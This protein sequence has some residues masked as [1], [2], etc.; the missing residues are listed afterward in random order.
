MKESLGCSRTE[1]LGQ[2]PRDDDAQAVGEHCNWQ[3]REDE[4]DPVSGLGVQHQCV[5][6]SQGQQGH[7]GP[8]PA[9][10]I[11]HLEGD[12]GEHEHV[13][14]MH[15]HD[16][17]G[18]QAQH[19]GFGD[20]QLEG[21]GRRVVDD[22]GDGHHEQE[23]GQWGKK[24]FEDPPSQQ[25]EHGASQDDDHGGTHGEILRG[26]PARE[27]HKEAKANDRQPIV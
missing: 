7:D 16:S 9:A 8:Q 15:D 25:I 4:D 13:A 19:R 26:Q 14:L 23:V 20:E 10:G 21:E 6:R 24:D 22:V 12:V 2:D 17:Q 5:R 3:G 27:Q 18:L 1:I 11:G